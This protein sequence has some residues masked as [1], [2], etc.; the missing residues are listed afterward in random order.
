MSVRHV[1]LVSID[2][3]RF[4]AVRWQPDQRYWAAL[5]IA[6]RL[7]TPTM[8]ALAGESVLFTKCVSN[9][10]YTPLSHATL[11]TGC[12]GRRH[13]VVNFHGTAC[14]PAV[15]TISEHFLR[16]GYRTF[17][18][19]QPGRRTLFCQTNRSLR[20]IDEHFDTDREFLSALHEHRDEP[21]FAVIHPCDVHDPLVRGGDGFP[22]PAQRMDWELFLRVVFNATPADDGS[23]DVVLHD[24]RR[25][26]YAALQSLPPVQTD[27]EVIGHLR[28]LCQAYLYTV[29]KLDRF[30]LRRLIEGMRAAGAWEDTLLVVTSDHGETQSWAYPWRLIHGALPDETVIRVPL[31]MRIPGVAPRQ[32]DHLV[33][34][35]DVL[36][37][38]LELAGIA[39]DEN[40]L[41]GRSLVPTI[42]QN[43]A[44]GDEYWI[45]GWSH[46]PGD[47]DPHIICRAIRCAN[48]RKYVWHGDTIDWPRLDS[49]TQADFQTYAARMTYGNPPS[50][51]LCGK[52]AT[53]AQQLGRE[54]ALRKL[55]SECRPRHLIFD[56]VDQDLTENNAVVVDPAHPRWAE[57]QAY[58]QKMRAQTAQ[59][60][61]AHRLTAE[62][63]Q[64]LEAHLRELG[65]VE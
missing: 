37:T 43:R 23:T 35:V 47:D 27:G 31:L 29:E 19:T 40:D 44:A 36:P 26:S 6:P 21:V 42:Q 55:L 62:E 48:G 28:R 9:A 30:R 20:H 45:E 16:V 60:R 33:G 4:D 54:G 32:C 2:D 50:E 57:Y 41:D 63:Q 58:Q 49:L 17:L 22:D 51:W 46:E 52:I 14:D 61:P 7:N 64:G 38:L 12:Y 10:G 1:I 11:F 18:L 24:G 8:D 13:G 3:L 5:G 15:A 53:L 39:V 34:L 65:Y 25:M 59:P 56:N